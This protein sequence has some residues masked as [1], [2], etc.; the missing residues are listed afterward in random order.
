[1]RIFCSFIKKSE[2]LFR[3]FSSMRYVI[4]IR[5]SLKIKYLNVSIYFKF[6]FMSF[7][8]LISQLCV[9]IVKAQT[10]FVKLCPRSF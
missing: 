5:L 9:I 8:T 10:Q 6:A 2:K 3:Y 1:M 7:V 4:N